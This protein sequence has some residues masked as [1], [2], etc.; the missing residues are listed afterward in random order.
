MYNIPV[1]GFKTVH[2]N[3]ESFPN[4]STLWSARVVGDKISGG[5]PLFWDGMSLAPG[6][7][8][9]L[10]WFLDS[11]IPSFLMGLISG[12]NIESSLVLVSSRYRL[13]A[14]PVMDAWKSTVSQRLFEHDVLWCGRNKSEQVSAPKHNLIGGQGIAPVVTAAGAGS[15][16]SDLITDYTLWRL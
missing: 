12:G 5:S 7:R 15:L 9:S 6:G 10:L 13:R 14:L 2:S 8:Y 3:V 11:W 4:R 1:S 16:L